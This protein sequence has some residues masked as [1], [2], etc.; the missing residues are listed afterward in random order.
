MI[1][2]NQNDD[3]AQNQ[4]QQI[5]YTDL[6]QNARTLIEDNFPEAVAVLVLKNGT[7]AIDGTVYLV[8]LDNNFELDFDVDG[9]P[10]DING[11]TQQVPDGLVMDAILEYVQT[12]YP[13][14]TII[15]IDF[16]ENGYEV[17][18]DN[19]VELYFDLDGNFVAEETD[20]DDD[21]DDNEENIPYE[22]LP[23]NTRNFIETHFSGIQ[24]TFIKRELDS[25]QNVKE[26][27]VKMANGFELE[28]SAD[29]NWTEVDGNHTAVPDGIIPQPI[30]SY[31]QQNYPA[32]L[33][34]EQIKTE[35]FGFEVEISNDLELMFDA[36]GN[37]IGI[38]D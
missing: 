1:G 21:D 5:D 35:N 12:H 13:A 33:Y 16:E 8:E 27:E 2:C 7:P 9:N 24:V 15:E 28:F 23:A 30:L 17:E 26:Y 37:F 20:D 11:N 6:P 14:N 32:P 18:L 25:N 29:G 31:I 3:S 36:E 4:Q 38:D 34:I 22:E 10:T 19:G